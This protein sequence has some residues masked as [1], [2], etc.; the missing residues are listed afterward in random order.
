MAIRHVFVRVIVIG[1][2]SSFKSFYISRRPLVP[3]FFRE[4]PFYASQTKILENGTACRAFVFE[5]PCDGS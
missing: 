3:F 4:S 1:I 5:V 2:E